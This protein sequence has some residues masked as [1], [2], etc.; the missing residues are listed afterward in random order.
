MLTEKQL[1]NI[2]ITDKLCK[3]LRKR[4]RTKCLKHP[5]NP[6]NRLQV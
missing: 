3:I 6:I 4:R 2:I 1:L 5:M